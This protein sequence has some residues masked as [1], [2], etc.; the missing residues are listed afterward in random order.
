MSVSRETAEATSNPSPSE[1]PRVVEL[2]ESDAGSTIVRVGHHHPSWRDVY[3]ALLTVKW[4]YFLAAVLASYLAVNLLFALL[5]F[6]GE[7]HIA[8]ARPGSF[9]DAFYFSV[10]TMATIGYGRMHPRT[11]FANILVTIEAMIG[12][13]SLA[14]ASALMF[15]R[16]ARPSARVLFSEVA[17]IGPHDGA[18]ALMFRAV[19]KR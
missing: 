9:A 6:S 1:P 3:H 2:S 14:L 11:D 17:V 4:R 8:E 12:T 19:N 5:Y 15:A 16:L 13:T 7:D 10:Q 18:P